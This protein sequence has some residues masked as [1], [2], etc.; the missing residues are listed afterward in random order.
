VWLYHYGKGLF[1]IRRDG[2]TR[3]LDQEE[4]FP[5]ERVDCFYED[6]EG[7]LWSGVDRGGLVRLRQK[8]FASLIPGDK[9][10][11]SAAKIAAVE[12]DQAG[13]SSATREIARGAA[14]AAVST[15]EDG[16]GAI[17][18]GTYGGGLNRWY[19]GQWQRFSVPSGSR[20]SF[21][22]SVCPDK[23]DRLWVSAGEEDLFMA[24]QEQFQAVSPAVH[25]VKALL[26]GKDGRVWIG[27]KSGLL[28]WNK[29]QL[30]QFRAESGIRRTDIRA[31]AED[32]N[33]A[34]WAGAG[35]G[36]LY[37]IISN[38]AESFQP[39][40]AL[41]AQPIW[42]LYADAD[43]TIWAGTFRGGLLRFKDGK[44]VR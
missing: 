37:R 28:S 30:R 43:G 3:Q 21:V 15:A 34:I 29:G 8:L 27:N 40:D 6:H 23:E 14:K 32:P 22:F 38:R 42:S 20:R 36:I 13:I 2:L 24:A 39:H 9:G 19:D 44:F 4:N 10:A 11:V 7:N 5:G 35:D 25:G 17:W 16:Q 18:I 33:G 1:H 31:L 41:A 12:E 26:A